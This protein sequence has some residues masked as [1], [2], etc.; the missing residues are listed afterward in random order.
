LDG[1]NISTVE[2]VVR[3]SL[4]DQCANLPCSFCS[5]GAAGA[6]H[7]LAR[8]AA[9]AW[10]GSSPAHGTGDLK[11]QTSFSALFLQKKKV[12]DY[13]LLK[14]ENLHRLQALQRGR[15]TAKWLLQP[16]GPSS[17]EVRLP[18]GA[19][20]SCLLGRQRPEAALEALLSSSSSSN[21]GASG[22]GVPTSSSSS[23][24]DSMA[25]GQGWPASTTLANVVLAGLAVHGHTADAV[26]LFDWM[27]QQAGDHD[28]QQQQVAGQ[29][30]QRQNRRRAQFSAACQPDAWTQ[31]L[32][33]FAGLNAPPEQQLE[34]T[35]RAVKE[36]RWA[37]AGL[38]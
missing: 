15:A 19:V 7:A 10:H 16:P 18:D 4:P 6:A 8:A 9:H 34:V 36:A 20:E 33:L 30:H 14:H 1:G 24:Q 27:K 5:G 38:A 31:R 37:V 22:S 21:F 12:N 23:S 11:Q 2:L 13:V 28:E 35:L 25:A 17:E 26:R 32:L 29:R 3:G